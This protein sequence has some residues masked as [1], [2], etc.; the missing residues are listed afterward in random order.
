MSVTGWGARA[1][2]I[3]SVVSLA[4]DEQALA[5]WSR[6]WPS[7]LDSSEAPTRLWCP[8]YGFPF[9][10]VSVHPAWGVG[11]AGRVVSLSILL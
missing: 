5:P 4:S 3:C 11:V 6:V 9:L 10:G 8:S 2:C 1:D 7:V